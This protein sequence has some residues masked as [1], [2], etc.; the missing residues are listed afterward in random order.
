MQITPFHH[1]SQS[2]WF[3]ESAGPAQRGFPSK[4]MENMS[5]TASTVT[6]PPAIGSRPRG[7]EQEM[8]FQVPGGWG[9]EGETPWMEADHLSHDELAFTIV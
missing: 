5:I 3:R 2:I 8:S 4:S 6:I 9:E 1:F 7:S